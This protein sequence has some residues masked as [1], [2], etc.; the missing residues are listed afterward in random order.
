MKAVVFHEFG[1]SEVL[2]YEDVPD[3]VAGPGEVV[4]DLKNAA[5]NHVDVDIREGV[6][7]FDFEMPHI[8]GIEGA[9]VI[10]AVGDGVDPARVGERVAVSYIRT[11]GACAW[12]LQGE[13]NLC[14]NRKLFGEHI[15]GSY[16]EK[17]VAPADHALTLP[18]KL[19]FAEAA[20]SMVA[21]GTA[22][23]G[24]V[25]RGGLTVGD[26]VLIHS[27]G[28]GVASAALQ[29]CKAAGATIIG[30]ASTDEKLERATADGADH[31][32]NYTRDD[33]VEAVAEHTQGQGVDLVF[34]V[35]GGQAFTQS[36][37]M[38]RPYGRLVSIGAHAGEVVDFDII[39]FFRR[40][41]SYISSH[42]Q[43]RHELRHV[44]N[45]IARGTLAPR[46]HSRYPLAEARAAHEELESRTA[47]GKIV[48]DIG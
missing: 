32:I 2:S 6:S 45:L 30:T 41:I 14:E 35:V 4:V 1:G 8:L 5:L 44:L 48:L 24:L 25:R 40:Q 33:V 12:C 11:C 31:V 19:D 34:D 9:G 20:A 46:I 47:Y 27:V 23:H 42:T 39:E 17:M 22:W 36:M 28:S 18:D 29:I 3:P 10:S 7:R 13:E 15:R 21:F 26:R 16:A 38:L 43:T 37:F